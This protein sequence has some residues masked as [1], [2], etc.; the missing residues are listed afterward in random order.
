V[1]WH[2]NN[3]VM[4]RTRPCTSNTV[5]VEEIRFF[6]AMEHAGN[7]S[8]RVLSNSWTWYFKYR[9]IVVMRIRRLGWAF[10]SLSM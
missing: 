2:A 5:V 8:C 1:I 4:Q 9:S 7:F 3:C 10:P 6:A